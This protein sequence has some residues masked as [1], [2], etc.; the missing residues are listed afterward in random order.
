MAANEEMRER[1]S[2]GG[3]KE[4][5]AD[6]GGGVAA[7]SGGEGKMIGLDSLPAAGLPACLPPPEGRK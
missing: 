5:M 3:K 1:G 7:Q 2:E 4:H 6:S